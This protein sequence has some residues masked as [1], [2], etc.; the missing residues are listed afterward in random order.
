MDMER[1]Y[2]ITITLSDLITSTTYTVRLSTAG[3]IMDFLHD[4]KGLALG[5]VAEHQGMV[6]VNPEWTFQSEK[7]KVRVKD[8]T[9][10]KGLYDIGQLLCQIIN[11]MNNGGL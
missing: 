10:D 2:D 3:V 11:R 4:G 7:M 9:D 8:G 5:K 6:E 1:T